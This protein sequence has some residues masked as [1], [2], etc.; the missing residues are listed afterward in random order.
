MDRFDAMRLFA[1]IVERGSFR[2]AASDLELSRATATEAIKH[3]EAR[4]GVRLLERTTR[5]VTT[6]LEGEEYY[7]RCQSILTEVEQAE[8]DLATDRPRGSLRISV[9]GYWARTF[10]VP[11][12]P[13]FL[14][15][16]PDLNLF[17]DEGDRLADMVREGF[18]CVLRH[19]QPD[20]SAMMSR[21]ICRLPEATCASPD[22]LASHGVPIDPNDLDGHAVIGFASSR[23]GSTLPLEFVDCGGARNLKLP[24]RVCVS[25]SET[26][27]MLA[28]QG[29]GLMQAPRFRLEDDFATGRLLEVL[30]DFAPEP[31]PV[32][33]LF[34]Q[35]RQLAPRVRVFLNW[36]GE[37]AYS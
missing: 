36:L 33:A 31:T 35:G 25:G 14:S 17:I 26:M 21:L 29:F 10:L 2:A 24:Y 18:D 8:G 6:T 4:L 20:D 19:G 27:V 9:H 11:H 13:A 23:T 32:F 12:L 7:R 28:R 1:R 30:S 37:L 5:H 34:P 3:L 15:R 22:Y 16:Y